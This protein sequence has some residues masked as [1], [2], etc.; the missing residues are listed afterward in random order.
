MKKPIKYN[1]I[2]LDLK[3]GDMPYCHEW[4]TRTSHCH[5]QVTFKK[6]IKTMSKDIVSHFLKTLK[7][8]NKSNGKC[9][10]EICKINEYKDS[11]KAEVYIKKDDEGR[12]FVMAGGSTVFCKGSTANDIYN[13]MQQCYRCGLDNVPMNFMEGNNEG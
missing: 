9:R 2:K 7:E 1:C 10:C 8:H 12:E 5:S 4:L 3:V 13:L 6:D 11:Y